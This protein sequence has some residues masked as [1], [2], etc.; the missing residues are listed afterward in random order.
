MDP[1]SS[2]AAAR[3]LKRSASCSNSTPSRTAS[4]PARS[5]P[6]KNRRRGPASAAPCIWADWD[7]RSSGTWAGC[8][9]S[10][11][12]V[13]ENPIHRRWHHNLITFSMLY[14][15]TENF[16]LP[17]S[18]DEVVHGKGALLDK[19][20]GDAGRGTRRSARST[21]TCTGIPA[22][23]C[24]SWAVSSASGASGIMTAASTGTCSTIRRTR[25]FGDW[26]RISTGSIGAS[27]R[28]TNRI[29]SVRVSDGLTATTTKTAW[30]H[31]SATRTTAAISS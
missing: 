30:C 3:I 25:A 23:S 2:S 8:T 7:S 12:Y 11:H 17:F 6:P 15:F 20:P 29:S 27:R 4:I 13:R 18:H 31:S 5:P 28:C 22:K 16:V 14:A 26:S 19:M 24:C 1:Q 9:T 10:S 21:V